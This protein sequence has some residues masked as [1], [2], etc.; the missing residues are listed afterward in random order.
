MKNPNGPYPGRQLF[1]GLTPQG[2]PAFAYLVTGRSPASRERQ[3]TPRDN[4]I[5][6]G[7]IGDAAYDPLR[8]YT[9]IKYDNASGVLAVSNGIQ[10]EAIYEAYKLLFN[11]KSAPSRGYMKKLMDGANYEPD[12]LQTP[13]I[14][15]VI[16]NNAGGQPVSI[17]S[18]KIADRPAFT[19]RVNAKAG[20]LSG[21]ATY[22][23]NMENP[24][25][26]KADKG[27]AEIKCD[28]AAPQEIAD[29]L[30]GI[31]AVEYKGDDIRVCAVA[32]VRTGNAW[33]VA[34]INRHKG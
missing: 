1:L 5:I 14:S 17:V 13:R 26:F 32:G 19:W 3:A 18:I 9:A 33:Q 15:G 7:P 4:G 25:A 34:H 10:T 16:T 28:A 11:V 20:R 27:L 21:V 6:M 31:S 24:G 8:H 30:Y 23:G 12:S 2:N 29:F 22:H